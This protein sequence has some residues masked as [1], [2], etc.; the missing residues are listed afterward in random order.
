MVEGEGGEGERKCAQTKFKDRSKFSRSKKKIVFWKIEG[1]SG[2][3]N[4]FE[5]A[6]FFTALTYSKSRTR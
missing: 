3:K 4:Y 1:I 5:N 2:L 6:Q